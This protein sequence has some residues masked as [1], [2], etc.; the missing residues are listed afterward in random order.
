M[1]FWV[2][3]LFGINCF[4]VNLTIKHS[5]V[6]KNL[7]YTIAQ[8]HFEQW[9]LLWKSTIDS[10]FEGILANRASEN[11]TIGQFKTLGSFINFN[12]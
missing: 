2:T 6:D 7:N 12:T 10:L 4:K 3:V 11:I 8:N 9:I 5:V 1:D